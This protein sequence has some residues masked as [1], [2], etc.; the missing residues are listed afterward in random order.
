MELGYAEALQSCPINP[1]RRTTLAAPNR[2][3]TSNLELIWELHHAWDR[4]VVEELRA[5]IHKITRARHIIFAPS[6]RAAIAQVLKTLPQHEVV[7][8]AY[9][10]PVVKTAVEF[11]G[12]RIRYVDISSS[13]LNATSGDYDEEATA[14]RILIPTHLFGIPTDIENICALA[15]ERGCI[16]IEDAAAALGAL[17]HGRPLGTFAD[18]GIFS[19]ERS[20]RFPAFRGAAIIVNNESV[21]DPESLRRTV[22]VP[23]KRQIPLR[24]LIFAALYNA[25]TQPWTYGRLVLPSLLRGHVASTTTAE[26]PEEPECSQFYNRAFLPYQA[27]LALRSLRRR[28]QIMQHIGRL[29]A[30]YD[31]ILAQANVQT[32]LRADYDQRGILRYPIAVRGLSRP[33]FLRQ[34]LS[35]GLYL[36]TNYEQPLAPRDEWSCF[37]NSLWSARNVVLLPL[38]RVLSE[39]QAETIARKVAAI[40]QESLEIYNRSGEETYAGHVA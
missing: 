27:A 12:K 36:E 20:K 17:W 9:S 13:S 19:F 33:E 28:D 35:R 24:E 39:R 11:A 6:G 7:M 8:P 3:D 29:V 15:R 21:I 37:P 34:A 32:F 18:V 14:G 1:Y 23:T 2:L 40:A 31:N 25:A 38:Y 5:E 22:V 26:A 16:T 4:S 30:I 10:C